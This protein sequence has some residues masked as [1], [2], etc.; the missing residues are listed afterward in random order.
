MALMIEEIDT[1][2]SNLEHKVVERTGELR[3]RE[4]DLHAQNLRFDAAV[5]NMSQG[6]VMFDSNACLVF[7]N[8]RYI[9]MYNLKQDDV[10]PGFSL[11]RLIDQR[12]AGGA[13]SGDPDQSVDHLVA[14]LKPGPPTSQYG[15]LD[16][17]RTIAMVNQPMAGRGWVATH[18]D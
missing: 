6:L 9:D 11:R 17:G 14:P 4:A 1:I 12:I 13:F 16:D 2:N 10:R 5:S 7:S 8:Q 3:A 18:E 15:G